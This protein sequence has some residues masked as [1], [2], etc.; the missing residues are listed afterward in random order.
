MRHTAGSKAHPR[1]VGKGDA[2]ALLLPRW[3]GSGLC[4]GLRLRSDQRT[5]SVQHRHSLHTTQREL[6][7]HT[8]TK[9]VHAVIFFWPAVCVCTVRVHCI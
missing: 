3:L 4:C 2:V 8:P 7:Q 5:R 9:Q 1:H 6:L